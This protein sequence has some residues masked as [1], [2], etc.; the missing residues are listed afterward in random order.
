MAYK[1]V[2]MTLTVAASS[3]KEAGDAAEA[4]T[5]VITWAKIPGLVEVTWNVASEPKKAKAKTGASKSAPSTVRG[6]RR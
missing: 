2:L 1:K 5:H 6:L 4:A 3:A